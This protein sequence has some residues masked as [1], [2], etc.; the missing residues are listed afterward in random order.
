MYVVPGVAGGVAF[1]SSPS[2]ARWEGVSG[3]S[4]R[5][6]FFR[7]SGEKAVKTL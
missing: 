1:G 4:T 5:S 3:M 6:S 2:K 7:N